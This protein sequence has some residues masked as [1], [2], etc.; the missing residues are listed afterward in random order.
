MP[1]KGARPKGITPAPSPRGNV[2]PPGHKNVRVF[3]PQSLHFQ[4]VSYSAASQ[5]S[6]HD[7]VVA[8]LERATPLK[9]ES[10]PLGGTSA[11]TP[12]CQNVL[13]QAPGRGTGQRPPSGQDQ[14]DGPGA[15]LS[16]ETKASS[17]PDDAPDLA[18][19]R[20]SPTV[21]LA[22]SQAGPDLD[23]AERTFSR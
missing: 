18:R 6:L 10:S 7:F 14:A 4:L 21:I 5:M 17:H 20:S 9:P 2:T 22:Q 13:E 23:K 8:W 11:S 1:D 19:S 3:V 15:A 12:Q 16:S